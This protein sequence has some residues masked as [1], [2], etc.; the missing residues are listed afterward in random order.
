[1]QGQTRSYVL[2]T[3]I[4]APLSAS[5][6]T[7]AN[8]KDDLDIPDA[9]TSND[10]RLTRYIAEESAAIA[11]Y[12]NRIFGL[13]TWQDDF[14]PERGIWGEGTRGAHNPLKL[15][16]CPMAVNTVNLIGN[17]H[18]S[19]LV[20]GLSSTA[21]LAAGQLV[22]GPGIPSGATILSVNTG[23]SSLQLSVPATATTTAVALSTGISVVETV[24][25]TA[26][27]LTV[28]ADFEIDKGS[29]LPSDEGPSLLYRLN[30]AGTPR[31]WP[32]AKITVVY[33]A[34]YLLPKTSPQNLN[35]ARPLPLDLEGAL[36]RIVVGRFRAKGR[37][38]MLVEQSQG[39]NLG[40]QRYWV[41]ATPGQTGPYPN[42]IMST[43]D[44]YRSV[45]IA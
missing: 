34:G 28:G 32:A 31:T 30:H 42:E 45:V 27:G 23:A 5:L 22:S 19:S 37:D 12:C 38:P 6:T 18:S 11:N 1:M 4:T 3:L 36:L 29:S 2:T 33:Q 20:D 8:I 44:N 25:G 43:L 15:T 7:L 41:G 10:K 39:A 9:D 24:A 40:T 14:R 17:T 16:R 35:G 26:T 21:G 13:A